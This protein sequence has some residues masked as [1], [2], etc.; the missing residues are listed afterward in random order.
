[1]AVAFVVISCNDSNADGDGI[2]HDIPLQV[3]DNMHIV[4]TDMGK[5]K[6]RLE[7]KT[8]ERY[9]NDSVKT[10]L[11][12][13]GFIAYAYDEDGLLETEIKGEQ[14]RHVSPADKQS[15]LK[16]LW[17]AYGNVKITNLKQRQI[18][19]TDTIFWDPNN[20]RIY[21]DCY[22][23]VID[24][25]GLMQGYGMESDQRARSTVF[26][27]VFNNYVIIDNDSTAVNIDTVNFIGP[28]PK[29]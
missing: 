14:A 13:E 23:R 2:N 16:E 12:P 29:K 18:M 10:D 19:E 28:F 25:K 3:V 9:E 15:S 8:M 5:F 27:R 7:A 26:R 17:M 1:M 4:Q 24:P 6:L 11:F 22:V 20:E 21:T